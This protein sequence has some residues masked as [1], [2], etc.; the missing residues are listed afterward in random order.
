MLCSYCNKPSELVTGKTIYPHRPDLYSKYFY[1]CKDCNAY[2]GCHKGTK[3]PMGTLAKA[4]LR[5]ARVKTHE[6]LDKIWK[7][8]LLSR[9]K[10]YKALANY[11]ELHIDATHIGLF[12]EYQCALTIVFA[13]RFYKELLMR[14]VT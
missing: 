13:K 9:Y 5:L 2:I 10:T 7:E 4:D 1:Y 3:E 11:T 8:T 12:D 6:A 14:K